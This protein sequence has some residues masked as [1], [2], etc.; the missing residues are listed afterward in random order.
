MATIQTL[1][2]FSGWCLSWGFF[3]LIIM[4]TS[5]VCSIEQ[6]F[7]YTP[8]TWLR[9]PT[10]QVL[11][12]SALIPWEWYEQAT[13]IILMPFFLSSVVI[14][15]VSQSYLCPSMIC[16]NHAAMGTLKQYGH[17]I[18]WNFCCSTGA[19]WSIQLN[20]LCA[21][22][23]K[24]KDI[25]IHICDTKCVCMCACVTKNKNTTTNCISL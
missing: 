9:F 17:M 4:I 6:W 23:E 1:Y 11:K 5:C 3:V 14:H 19:W 15:S 12:S 8:G 25:H 13:M 2:L 20:K 10:H 21:G 22:L 7:T 16:L 18:A 24:K